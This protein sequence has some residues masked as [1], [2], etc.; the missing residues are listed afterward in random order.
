MPRRAKA[1]PRLCHAPG[2]TVEVRRGML[3]CRPHWFQLP[4]ALRAAINETWKAGAIREWSANCLE[5]S[6]WLNENGPAAQIARL[7]GDST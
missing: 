5:A 4:S 3:M 7:T 6:R 2:C 1:P